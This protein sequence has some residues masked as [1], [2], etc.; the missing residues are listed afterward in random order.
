[1][2]SR[3]I[4]EDFN[5]Y[6]KKQLAA[7]V[8]SLAKTANQRLRQLEKSGMANQSA[9][10]GYI[11]R[12]AFDESVNKSGKYE[13]MT[14]TQNGEIKFSTNT[15]GRTAQ[16]LKREAYELQ[17]FLHAETSTVK[18]T[19]AV[20]ERSRKAF[21]D[22]VQNNGGIPLTQE[23]YANLGMNPLL[24]HY[25]DLYG[26]QEFNNMLWTGYHAGIT[27]SEIIQLL[28]D[29]GFTED[30]EDPGDYEIGKIYQAF[31]DFINDRDGDSAGQNMRAPTG[32]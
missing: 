2:A 6:T 8:A 3:Y 28:R 10:Y 19:K 17:K 26:S 23:E 12:H 14:T 15:R 5:A 32:I 24:K 21:N 11:E 16:Q 9:A 25:Y 20:Q 22:A 18:G 29:T 27:Q 30:I 13:Y 1:M 4:N 31:E 7:V